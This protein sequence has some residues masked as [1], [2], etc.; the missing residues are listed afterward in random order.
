MTKD[1]KLEDKRFH[2]EMMSKENRLQN[3]YR[4]IEKDVKEFLQRL[5]K[6]ISKLEKGR[7]KEETGLMIWDYDVYNLIDKLAGKSL[8]EKESQK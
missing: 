3:I 5:K 7:L 8:V 1:W 2:R 6:E 4:Y